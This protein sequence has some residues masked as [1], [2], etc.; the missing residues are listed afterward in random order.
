MVQNTPSFFV[1]NAR[2]VKEVQTM[3]LSYCIN[4]CQ[5]PFELSVMDICGGLSS[6]VSALKSLK[7]KHAITDT[8]CTVFIKAQ[9]YDFV[10]LL[11]LLI[12]KMFI[13]RDPTDD[14]KPSYNLQFYV[15]DC[16]IDI[17]ALNIIQLLK[18]IDTTPVYRAQTIECQLRVGLVDPGHLGELV[19]AC[20]HLIERGY[21]WLLDELRRQTLIRQGILPPTEY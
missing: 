2:F 8:T 20:P 3:A 12:A 11:Y 6:D 18:Y 4:Y 5:D 19:A 10:L 13:E 9:T 1:S 21:D 15:K 17:E 7:F 16:L 14:F